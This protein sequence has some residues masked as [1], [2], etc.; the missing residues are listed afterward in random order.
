M[1]IRRPSI[2]LEPTPV[3]PS[4]LPR[5]FQVVGSHRRRAQFLAV[6]PH[7]TDVYEHITRIID[8]LWFRRGSF[9]SHHL[10][11]GSCLAETEGELITKQTDRRFRR[12]ILRYDDFVA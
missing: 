9:A 1:S 4:G 10:R 6:R 5:A 2:S 3:T 7:Y 8:W 12:V 11:R